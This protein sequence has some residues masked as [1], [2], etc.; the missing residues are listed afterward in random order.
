LPEERAIDGRNISGFLNRTSDRNEIESFSVP[1]S[2]PDNSF[3]ALREGPWKLHVKLTSQLGT[4]HGFHASRESPLLFQLEQDLS[5][6]F[7]R[8][9]EHPEIVQQLPQALEQQEA[10]VAEEGTFWDSPD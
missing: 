3:F 9:D 4:D 10:A 6:R 1:F 2:G 7:D 5:E 8:S